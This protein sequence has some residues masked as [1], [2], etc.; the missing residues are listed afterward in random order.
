MKNLYLIRH[1]KSDWDDISMHDFDRPL[2]KRGLRNAPFM[3]NILSKKL[4]SVDAIISSPAKR[5][6]TTARFFA[7]T[8]SINPSQIIQE[9]RIY[10]APV[11]NLLAV[12]NGIDNN[13]DTVLM[14]GHNPGFSLLINY[15]TSESCE[16]PTCAIA[17]VQFDLDNWKM[18]SSNLGKLIELDF[19]KKH[20]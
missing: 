2:N 14:F 16:M 5:A 9:E 12:I 19:P 20:L 11:A 1:A 10:E 4:N 6:I 15:L 17:H 18:V 3:A 7:E 8:F 13:Y